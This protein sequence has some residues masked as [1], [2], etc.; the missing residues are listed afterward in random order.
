MKRI[1][2]LFIVSFLL[3][4]CNSDTNNEMILKGDLALE[5]GNFEV[6]RHTYEQVFEE[7]PADDTLQ[8]KIKMLS[9]YELL[10][11]KIEASEWLAASEFAELILADESL[12]NPLKTAVQDELD[13][14]DNKL[15]E[16]KEQEKKMLVLEQLKEI[17]QLIEQNEFTEADHL[18]QELDDYKDDSI[19]TLLDL[20]QN[21]NGAKKRLADEQ[22]QNEEEAR[23]L[24]E[25][26]QRKKEDKESKQAQKENEKQGSG[27]YVKDQFLQKV[28]DVEKDVEQSFENSTHAGTSESITFV[29][30]QYEKWDNLLNEVYQLI[31]NHLPAGEFE[32]LKKEQLEWIEVKETERSNIATDTTGG[33]IMRVHANEYILNITEEKTKELIER[34]MK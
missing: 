25:E 24:A 18:L 22:Q 2:L 30:E 7:N 23:K 12:P 21:L 9:D 11:E 16:K 15:T 10:L 33:T 6:A 31:K 14:I 3:V 8:A 34:Y 32:E 26:E 1:M 13:Y 29:Y 19:R 17:Q 20:T 4:S 28:A 5:A 27:L